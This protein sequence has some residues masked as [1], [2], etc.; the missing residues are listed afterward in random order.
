MP[1]K[2]CLC[3]VCAFLKIKCFLG[4]FRAGTV[5]RR[6]GPKQAQN[7][8][9]RH[10]P[11]AVRGGCARSR[12]RPPPRGGA[13]RRGRLVKRA[14]A[15]ANGIASVRVQAGPSRGAAGLVKRASALATNVVY[16]KQRNTERLY[17]TE[18]HSFVTM[19]CP[20]NETPLHKPQIPGGIYPGSGQ[21]RGFGHCAVNTQPQVKSETRLLS[22]KAPKS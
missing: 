8:P 14:R 12:R 11:P 20:S 13:P 9:A 19:N 1:K 4:G 15:L 17:K 6:A 10:N 3:R 5:P 22:P 21:S 18:T 7:P 16:I 2:G